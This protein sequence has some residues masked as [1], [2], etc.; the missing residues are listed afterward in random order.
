CCLM[1][2]ANIQSFWVKQLNSRITSKQR[3]IVTHFLT[4]WVS[5]LTDSTN[6]TNPSDP[7]DSTVFVIPMW[8]M[9]E[10]SIELA[11]SIIFEATISLKVTDARCSFVCLIQLLISAPCLNWTTSLDT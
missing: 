8:L 6:S 10:T 11:A 5:Y 9:S 7:T 1:N 3:H 4:S 2:E